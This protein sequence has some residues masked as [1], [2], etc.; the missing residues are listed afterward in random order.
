MR[1]VI[2]KE[3]AKLLDAFYPYLCCKRDQDGMFLRDDA[4]EEAKKAFEEYMNLPPE[5]E[6]DPRFN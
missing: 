6:L 3:R 5:P 2:P 4:P 1:I